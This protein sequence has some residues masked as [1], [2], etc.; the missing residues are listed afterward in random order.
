MTLKL[1]HRLLNL[2]LYEIWPSLSCL[3][4]P[5]VQAVSQGRNL[6]IL[7]ALIHQPR[8]SDLL[9]ST[10]KS[11]LH[12]SPAAINVGGRTSALGG[13]KL[14]SPAHPNFFGTVL[15]LRR[16]NVFLA[17]QFRL[18]DHHRSNEGLSLA[19]VVLFGNK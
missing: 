13:A 17:Y 10:I 6:P 14:G 16:D 9:S 3:S 8:C 2:S 5:Q 12:D 7:S 15:L 4:P 18:T 11:I 1:A 19:L